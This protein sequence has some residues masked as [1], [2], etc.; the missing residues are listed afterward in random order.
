MTIEQTPEKAADLNSNIP[1]P[2]LVEVERIAAIQDPVIRNLQITQCYYELSAVFARRSG[3]SANWCTFAT[4]ASKQAGQ[5]IRR[6]DLK[7]LL[8]RRLSSAPMTVQV[9]VGPIPSALPGGASPS[10][11]PQELIL[12]TDDFTPAIELASRAVGRGNLKVF[13]EIGR[14]F[15]RFFATCLDDETPKPENI[16]HFCDGL[17]TG[18]PPEGQRYLRQAFAHYYQ[19]LFE[20]DA[21]TRAE[22]FLLANIEIGFHEQTRL[23]PEIAESLDAGLI[24]SVQ[25]TRKLIAKIF[26]FRKT[27]NMMR[28]YLMRLLGRPTALD[29]AIGALLEAAQTLLREAITE[30]M[31]TIS[32]PHGKLVRLGEDLRASFPA[33]LRQI[34]NPELLALL[35]ALDPTP[36]SSAGSGAR[37][38]ANLPDRLHFIIDLFRCYQENQDLF[39]PPFTSEQVEALKAGRLPDGSL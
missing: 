16:A 6:E 38:W 18:D 8:E 33:S 2:T 3:L 36:D 23:Q 30:V 35:E 1:V 31:M 19:A 27:V 17:R 5:T 15:A 10:G 39:E 28:L 37:D 11:I 13:K 20:V 7:R 14:Q 29:P 25:F 21:K 26:P 24:S 4:W 32:L 9:G 22:L 34:H 12:E